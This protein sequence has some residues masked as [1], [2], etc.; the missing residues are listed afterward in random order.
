[1]STIKAAAGPRSGL[2]STQLGKQRNTCVRG[3]L[4]S[5]ND[6]D[7]EANDAIEETLTSQAPEKEEEKKSLFIFGLG[8]VGSALAF[9]LAKEG[10]E[11][12]GTVTN[13]DKIEDYRQEGV[14]AMLFNEWILGNVAD[15]EKEALVQAT[16]I[17]TSVPPASST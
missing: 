15:E 8:Y 13:P 11:V 14:N 5:K 7:G 6:E 17:L 2:I 16:H 10:W 12:H 4:F 3:S 1:A 9:K